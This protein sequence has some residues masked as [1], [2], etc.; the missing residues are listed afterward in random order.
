MRHVL[1]ALALI[2]PFLFPWPFTAALALLAAIYFPLAP[3]IVGMLTDVLYY[4]HGAA[5]YG[6]PWWSTVGLIA[7][8][9]AYGVR[10]FFET[11]IMHA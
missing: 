5:S 1:F 6:L 10:G 2:G 9:I 7:T 4:A 8:L 11:S 3:V